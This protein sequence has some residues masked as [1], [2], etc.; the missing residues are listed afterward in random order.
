M[1]RSSRRSAVSSGRSCVRDEA[2][3]S[4]LPLVKSLVGRLK[5]A[6]GLRTS[7]EDLVGA[8]VIGLLEAAERFEPDRGVAFTTFAYRRIRGAILDAQRH[9]CDGSAGTPQVP[10]RLSDLTKQ[11]PANT[12]ALPNSDRD[13][14]GASRVATRTAV[15][16]PVSMEGI[17]ESAL[18]PDEEVDRR[19]QT[20]RLRDALVALS[21]PE[22]RI[23][24][25]HYF[26]GESFSGIGARLGICKPWAFR[27]H[28]RALEKLREALGA[29][30]ERGDVPGRVTA[31]ALS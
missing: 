10:L 4:Y 21:G 3:E 22:R 9:E 16:R 24:E 6:Y 7:F 11:R 17:D 8:G 29:D 27:L 13:G 20:H 18:T 23:L 26:E 15:V 5:V 2:V 30:L 1:K 25:L 12:N 28:Q 19:R 31:R 14:G